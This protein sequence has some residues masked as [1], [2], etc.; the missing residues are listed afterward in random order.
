MQHH[1]LASQI[2]GKGVYSKESNSTIGCWFNG[3]IK[4]GDSRSSS[5][6]AT[7]SSDTDVEIY[8][9]RHAAKMTEL[10]ELENGNFE[11]VC[12]DSKCSEI[13]NTAG[14]LRAELLVGAFAEAGIT[15]RLAH[16]FSSHKTR[17]RQTIEAIV[18]GLTG[19]VEK[20]AVDGIQENP[21][22]NDDGTADATELDPQSTSG[23]EQPTIDAILGLQSGSVALV[24]G[25]N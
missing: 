16:A 5:Q 11:E 10:K 12:G 9:T 20:N 25:H 24:A 7:A 17:T 1:I 14:E 13:L 23:S 18:A 4:L 19:D 8:F 15:N 6:R 3:P 2:F 21:V 22:K